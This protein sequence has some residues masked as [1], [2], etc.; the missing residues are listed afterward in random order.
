V[1]YIIKVVKGDL[2][3]DSDSILSRWKDHLC[4]L[5]DIHG[6]T[7]VRQTEIHTAE[8][9]VPEASAFKGEMAIER[10]QRYK[11]P[12]IDQTPAELIQAECKE[13]CSDII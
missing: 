3:A 7:Y 1:T 5:L 10:L 12:G 11:S 4:Q 8:P 13:V 2:V 6:V 9:V